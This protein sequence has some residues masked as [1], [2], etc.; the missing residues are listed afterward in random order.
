MYSELE[1]KIS[2]FFDLGEGSYV[3]GNAI[4]YFANGSKEFGKYYIDESLL[5]KVFLD[6]HYVELDLYNLIFEGDIEIASDEIALEDEIRMAKILR[7]K[8]T[9]FILVKERFVLILEG[10]DVF[11]LKEWRERLK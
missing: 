10:I 1:E 2:Q 11:Q 3:S 6:M 4:V 9:I 7:D 8:K 5:C